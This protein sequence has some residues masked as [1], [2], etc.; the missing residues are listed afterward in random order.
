MVFDSFSFCIAWLSEPI[1]DLK[2]VKQKIK[3]KTGKVNLAALNGWV[4]IKHSCIRR[5]QVVFFHLGLLLT[6]AK[7]A[8]YSVQPQGFNKQFEILYFFSLYTL[9]N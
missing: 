4:S 1:K 3:K 7:F 6:D 8:K 5:P 2:Q 9:A